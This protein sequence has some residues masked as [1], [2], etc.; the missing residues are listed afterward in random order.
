MAYIDGR[1]IGLERQLHN[2]N[3]AVHAGA[4]ASRVGE[5]DFH[6][7][8]STPTRT[9]SNNNSTPAIK[10][11]SDG[12]RKIALRVQYLT[13]FVRKRVRRKGLLEKGRH[14]LQDPMANHRVIGIA[15]QI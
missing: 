3:G 6:G 1:P 11:S 5:I 7:V 9:E 10:R 2:I 14:R 8:T 4:K 15:R 13:N 12:C